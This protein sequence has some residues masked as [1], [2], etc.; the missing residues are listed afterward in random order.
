MNRDGVVLIGSTSG[1]L[2]RV[3]AYGRQSRARRRARYGARRVGQVDPWFLPDGRHYLF[4]LSKPRASNRWS[5]P[6]RFQRPAPRSSA[7]ACHAGLRSARPDRVPARRTGHG[8]EVRCRAASRRGERRPSI[9]SCI[10]RQ[11]SRRTRGRWCT[12]RNWVGSCG[13]TARLTAGNSRLAWFDR[14]RPRDG[15]HHAA[16]RLLQ[17]AA[18]PRRAHR[19]RRAVR[20]RERGRPVDDRSASQARHARHVRSAARFGPGV[21]STRRSARMVTEPDDVQ[22][23][24]LVQRAR[25]ADPVVLARG[26]DRRAGTLRVGLVARRSIH[27]HPPHGLARQGE[28]R[29]PARRWRRAGALAAEPTRSEVG[30]RFS[31]DGQWVA[32]VSTETGATESLCAC[33]S[34]RPAKG[35]ESSTRGGTQPDWRRRWPRAVLPRTRTRH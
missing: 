5:G 6:P 7:N 29:V 11:R 20:Q 1:P 32:Y 26:T 24:I 9:R 33:R 31:P 22:G 14:A 8:A 12:A 23:E 34:L 13:G 2:Q 10:P 15:G 28:N 3:P 27:R 30:A 35:S 21:V 19:R 18:G 25:R 17:P 4:R 16:R